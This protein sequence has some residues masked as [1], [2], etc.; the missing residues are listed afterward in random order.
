MIVDFILHSTISGFLT[1]PTLYKKVL[2]AIP[3]TIIFLKEIYDYFDYGL[4]SWLDI[5]FG[6]T[7]ISLCLTI[8]GIVIK[9][10]HWVASSKF[11]VRL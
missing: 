8:A 11:S 3:I 9:V 1:I 7:G 5:V 4:F 6:F 2:L 10:K